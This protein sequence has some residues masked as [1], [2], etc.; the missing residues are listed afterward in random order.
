MSNEVVKIISNGENM[1][2]QNSAKMRF[3]PT[4]VLMPC[5]W[6][7]DQSKILGL[8]AC[9]EKFVGKEDTQD[10]WAPNSENRVVQC[11]R[12][13]QLLSKC[14]KIHED[15]LCAC[16]YTMSIDDDIRTRN[17]YISKLRNDGFPDVENARKEIIDQKVPDEAVD[18]IVGALLAQGT[19]PDIDELKMELEEGHINNTAQVDTALS[20]TY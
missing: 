1:V 10:A 16:Y 11:Y 14:S 13:I 4:V 18:K 20:L 19:K 8:S 15:T 7:K 3:R 9:M 5:E 6:S 2:F 17:E 12:A